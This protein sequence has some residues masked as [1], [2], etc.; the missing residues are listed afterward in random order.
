[1]MIWLLLIP[2]IIIAGFL[3]VDFQIS[4]PAYK[5]PKT[6]HFDGRNFF[7][8]DDHNSKTSRSV[9]NMLKWADIGNR[10]EWIQL[11]DNDIQPSTAGEPPEAPAELQITFI[12]HSTF[13]IQLNGM[14]ILTDPVWSER[15]SPYTWVG[16]KRMRPPGVRFDD[17][18]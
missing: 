7:N 4:A 8:P 2:A 13:L 14:S 15:V 1:Y 9:F 16:T 5:G 18:P 11:G 6:D 3:I 17:L 10:G 12:N